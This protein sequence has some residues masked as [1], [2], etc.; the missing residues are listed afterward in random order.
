MNLWLYKKTKLLG[1]EVQMRVGD[2]GPTI[3]T[4]QLRQP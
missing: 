3:D 4:T 2:Y 1:E